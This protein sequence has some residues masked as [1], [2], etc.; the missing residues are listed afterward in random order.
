[1][2]RIHDAEEK[3][4]SVCP[5]LINNKMGSICSLLDIM[6]N[7]KKGVTTGD[8]TGTVFSAVNP[9]FPSPMWRF[10]LAQAK[11]D[12]GDLDGALIELSVAQNRFTEAR[13]HLSIWDILGYYR[14]GIIY[15]KLGDKQKAIIS[16]ETFLEH[17]GDADWKLGQVIDARARLTMLRSTS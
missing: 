12:L 6:I 15:E 2:G 14:A 9:L 3:R 5:L 1:M 17:W 10:L 8:E 13:L 11:Y 7:T 16:L 4:D